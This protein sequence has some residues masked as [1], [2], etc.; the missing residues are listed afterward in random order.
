MS[1]VNKNSSSVANNPEDINDHWA[2]AYIERTN[3]YNISNGNKNFEPNKAI[4]RGEF[5]V[6]IVNGFKLTNGNKNVSFSD[7]N[8]SAFYNNAVKIAASNNIIEG[9]GDNKFEPDRSIS[10]QEAMTIMYRVLKLQGYDKNLPTNPNIIL[11]RFP[12]AN[13]VSPWAAPFVSFNIE[14]K[15]I[16]GRDLDIA[17][18]GNITRAESVVVVERS[19]GLIK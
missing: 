5:A 15:I 8:D 14:N 9:V 19:V 7:V 18:L 10:R 11:N 17:P 2:K 16:Q 1:D 6:A 4:T 13:K 12:D 3:G